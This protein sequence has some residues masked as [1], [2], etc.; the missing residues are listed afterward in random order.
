MRTRDLV[1][2]AEFVNPQGSDWSY[3]FLIRR[4]ESERLEVV[5]LD[6]SERWFHYTR[7]VGDD[8]YTEKARLYLPG[9]G[10]NLLS[11]NRLLL[12]AIEES[13]WY[14]VNSHW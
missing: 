12:I 4:P 1:V 5:G 6:G 14:F 10:I 8:D 11:S 3:G 2:E 9:A 7:D 13:G